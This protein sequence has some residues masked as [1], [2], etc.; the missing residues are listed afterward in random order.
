MS[1]HTP[2][3]D[4][5]RE[6]N[7]THLRVLILSLVNDDLQMTQ[8]IQLTTFRTSL[9]SAFYGGCKRDTARIL[10]LSAVCCWAPAVQHCSYHHH[11][12]HH[13]RVAGDGRRVVAPPCIVYGYS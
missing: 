9:C 8:K 10:L 1:L 2:A 11:R 13:R 12:H 5:V 3:H 4:L 6:Q 7:A